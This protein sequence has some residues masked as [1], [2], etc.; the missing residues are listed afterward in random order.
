MKSYHEL[1]ALD[2]YEERLKYLR[3]YSDN[4]GNQDRALMNRFYKSNAWKVARDKAIRRDLGCD[5]GIPNLFIDNDTIVVH[6]INPVTI[7]DL[8]NG[9]D[10]LL[11]MDNLIT[12]SSTTHNIIH[13]AKY[14]DD[15]IVER[16][17]GDTIL[18]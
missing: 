3:V 6:H 15:E 10:L 9:S 2:S 16:K 4:P 1:V 7:D 14:E 12:V 18:W 13:Y 8:E 17:P 5:L 11:D